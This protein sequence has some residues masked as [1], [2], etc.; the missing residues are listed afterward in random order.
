MSARV[1]DIGYLAGASFETLAPHPYS[2]SLSYIQDLYPI[3]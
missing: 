3:T 1:N 2:R